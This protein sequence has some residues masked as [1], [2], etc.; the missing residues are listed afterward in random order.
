M[1]ARL[2]TDTG[3][4][5]AT[6]TG[7]DSPR[8]RGA[9]TLV[10]KLAK[11]S[12]LT[13]TCVGSTEPE[14]LPGYHRAGLTPTCVGSALLSDR[15]NHRNRIPREFVDERLLRLGER[16]PV[17]R[18]EPDF[19]GPEPDFAPQ[20]PERAIHECHRREPAPGGFGLDPELAAVDTGR[21]VRSVVEHPVCDPGSDQ[22]V[23]VEA[24]E[25]LAFAVERHDQS[26]TCCV[27]VVKQS[28]L[29]AEPINRRRHP[30]GPTRAC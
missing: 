25:P 22:P 17:D 1:R 10:D 12:G 23:G 28:G 21:E 15:S 30:P 27:R 3:Q 2:A 4:A 20:R 26:L 9:Q 13:P 16:Q 19:L 8:L 29:V 5:M 6:P 18:A 11:D 14:T 7:L 24:D